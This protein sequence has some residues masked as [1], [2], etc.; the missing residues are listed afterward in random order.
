MPSWIVLRSA[1][2]PSTWT[3]SYSLRLQAPVEDPPRRD[4][5]HQSKIRH[6][7]THCE[8]VQTR[9]QA[10]LAR[11]IEK[12]RRKSSRVKNLSMRG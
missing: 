11:K 4:S 12:A 1:L 10:G 5:A 9:R 7:G 2:S 3:T 6:G 8:W